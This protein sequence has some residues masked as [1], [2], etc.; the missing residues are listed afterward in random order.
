M[1]PALKL[2]YKFGL[3]GVYLVNLGK[4]MKRAI[5]VVRTIILCATIRAGCT[6]EKP[7]SSWSL[8]NAEASIRLKGFIASQE[9]LARW[10]A[11]Q[12]K[13]TP[14]VEFDAFFEAAKKGNWQTATNLFQIISKHVQDDSSIHGSWWPAVIEA[15]G[16]FEI[17][18]SNDKC[19]TAFGDEIIQSIPSG[20]I[21]FGGTDRGWFKVTAL[22]RSHA[23]G[24]PF[25]YIR[26]KCI[27]GWN[28]PGLFAFDV[29]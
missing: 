22:S 17:F 8:E 27:C 15:G 24:D 2:I 11:K 3:S 9:I 7:G 25:F 19:E 14:P 29:W 5:H 12:D 1:A 6:K 16:V 4:L 13:M 20:S 28:L 18:P 23:D 10:L 21:F 26:A